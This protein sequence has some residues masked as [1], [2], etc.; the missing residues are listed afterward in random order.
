MREGPRE[1]EREEGREGWMQEVVK[2]SLSLETHPSV[3]MLI[4]VRRR[5]N[6][7]GMNWSARAC[8][9]GVMNSDTGYSTFM[10]LQVVCRR[11]SRLCRN[12]SKPF[13]WVALGREGKEEVD[14]G[15]DRQTVSLIIGCS[16]LHDELDEDLNYLEGV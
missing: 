8:A 2:K 16:G 11:S 6:V 1:E 9:R 13:P 12:C 15:M 5:S 10:R 3:C 14:G 4:T 7:W